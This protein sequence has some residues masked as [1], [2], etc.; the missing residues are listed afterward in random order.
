M[1]YH[2]CMKKLIS[3][4]LLT[5]TLNSHAKIGM[6]AEVGN[7]ACLSDNK[8]KMTAQV[9]VRLKGANAKEKNLVEKVV[10]TII[11]LTNE[12]QAE[13]LLSGLTI[14]F[15]DVL[16]QSTTGGCLP[17]HQLVRNQIF[18]ARYCKRKNGTHFDIPKKEG[19]L[20]HEIG[21]FVANKRGFYPQYNEAVSQWRKCKISRYMVQSSSG[22][23]HS[24]RNEEFAEVFAAYLIYPKELKRKCKKSYNFLKDALFLGQH[25]SCK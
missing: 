19:I 20:I 15:E 3:V 1:G 14:N 4:L 24:N 21:H 11:E 25:Q 5:F 6:I 22:Q 17:A 2:Q 23:K 9:G 16:R 13:R 12:Q 10:Q 18:M 8:G 7:L